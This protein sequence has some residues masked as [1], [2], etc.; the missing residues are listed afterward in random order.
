MV[1][2]IIL[3]FYCLMPTLRRHPIRSDCKE[4]FV[5]HRGLHSINDG[6]PENSLLAI[7][8]A[9]EKGYGVEIDI[10][11]TKDD[12]VVIMHDSTLKRACGIEDSVEKKTYD[13]IRELKLFNTEQKIPTLEQVLQV[14]DGKTTLLIE[15]K[16]DDASYARLC[17][18]ANK[19][20]ENYNGKYLVQS[21]NP[22]PMLWY[23][24]N[25]PDVCRGQL[26]SN[27]FKNPRL[28][29]LKAANSILMLNVISRPD[30]IS[31]NRKYQNFLPRRLC[32][33]FGALHAGWTFTSM[34]QV[35]KQRKHFDIFIFESFLP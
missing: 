12:R 15:F 4:L 10:R 1:V 28:N 26:S 34:E 6:V 8:R 3:Y 31:Y 16:C 11:M 9:V 25:R 18:A 14:V 2:L 7:E 33:I 23:R 5:A 19:I 27:F 24:K 35:E 13:E 21:F 32:S 22:L 17:I 20:L 30:F 29:I